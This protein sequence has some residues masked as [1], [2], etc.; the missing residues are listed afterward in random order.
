MNP[1]VQT[2][3]RLHGRLEDVCQMY[4]PS[5]QDKHLSYCTVSGTEREWERVKRHAE[6]VLK[7]G[8]RRKPC[9]ICAATAAALHFARFQAFSMH[10]ITV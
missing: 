3:A 2:V 8:V 4:K 9:F 6:Q 7:R 5:T 1:F 10:S